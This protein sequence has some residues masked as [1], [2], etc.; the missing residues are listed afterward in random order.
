MMTWYPKFVLT[1]GDNMGLSTVE[2][3]R[4]NAASWN[5][6]FMT[7]I[8]FAYLIQSMTEITYNHRPPHHPAKTATS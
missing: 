6:P 2:G 7:E 4:A 3:V 1:K 8:N 5:A